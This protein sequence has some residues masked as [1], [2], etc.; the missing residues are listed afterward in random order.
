MVRVLLQGIYHDARSRERRV[1]VT[2][3]AGT[4][5]NLVLLFRKLR[6]P[7][8]FFVTSAVGKPPQSSG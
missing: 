2:W 8:I 6:V 4:F 7:L 3:P 1:C 5:V